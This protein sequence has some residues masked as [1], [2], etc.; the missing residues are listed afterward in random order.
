MKLLKRYAAKPVFV[1][2]TI[3]KLS[4]MVVPPEPVTS[5]ESTVT[6][7]GKHVEAG[8][9]CIRSVYLFIL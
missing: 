2:K 3:T 6:E 1:G 9:T 8:K 4:M 5:L 7:A